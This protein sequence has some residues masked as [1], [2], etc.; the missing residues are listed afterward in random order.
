M[1]DRFEDIRTF[2]TVVQAKSFAG[3]AERLGVV[4]S[5]VRRFT[6]FYWARSG[7]APSEQHL[8]CRGSRVNSEPTA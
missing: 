6:A 8:R 2:I 1:T 7:S 4:K 3:A 5:A